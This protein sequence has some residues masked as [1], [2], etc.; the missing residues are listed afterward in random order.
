MILLQASAE[1]FTKAVSFPFH[2]LG[3]EIIDLSV[4]TLDPL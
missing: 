3:D 1:L 4:G 2:P